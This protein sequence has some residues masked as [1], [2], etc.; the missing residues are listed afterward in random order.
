LIVQDGGTWGYASSVVWDPK[1]R[2]GVVVLS[3]HVAAVDDIGRHLLRPSVPLAR[4]A[5]RP[6]EISVDSDVLDAYAGRYEAV[7]E[8]IFVIA[9]E[10]DSL[11]I[12]LPADWG[13]PKLRLR[14]QALRDFFA[15]ELPLRVTFQTGSDGRVNGILVH[16]PRGQKPIPANRIKPGPQR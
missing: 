7:G 8:G 4:P 9:R 1:S 12:E 3:N 16:P 6:K 13:L 15:A 11:M 2:R 10:R 14:P 5:K